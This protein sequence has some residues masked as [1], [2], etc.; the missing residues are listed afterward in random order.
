MGVDDLYLIVGIVWWIVGLIGIIF[1]IRAKIQKPQIRSDKVEA[2]LNAQNDVLK[3]EIADLKKTI[4][5]NKTG[6]E[7][8]MQ[9]LKDNHIH[10]LDLKIDETNKN[11]NSLTLKVTELATIINERIPK[12]LVK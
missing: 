6:Q 3:V 12:P 1:T 10:S 7:K 5:D 9:N 2:L 4:C 8:E 11:V